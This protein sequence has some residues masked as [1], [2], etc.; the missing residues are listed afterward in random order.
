MKGRRR[1][2]SPG[3]AVLVRKGHPLGGGDGPNRQRQRG[4]PRSGA[5]RS[6]QPRFGGRGYC[7]SAVLVAGGADRRTSDF[8]TTGQLFCDRFP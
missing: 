1:S 8:R 7:R 2:G 3:A 6:I 4:L 5:S